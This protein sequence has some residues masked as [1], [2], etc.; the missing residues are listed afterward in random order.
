M[1]TKGNHEKVTKNVR[2]IS[3]AYLFLS[4][5]LHDACHLVGD[6]NL[7]GTLGE[8]DLAVATL[9]S[10]GGGIGQG[11]LVAGDELLTALR[12]V[13]CR[14]LGQGQQVAVDCLVVVG[15]VSRDVHSEGARHAVFAGGAGNGG[16]ARHLVGNI[17]QQGVFGLGTGLEGREGLDILNQMFH[18]V[19]ATERG[20]DVGM[21]TYPAEGPAS[22]TVVR[23]TGFQ[24]VSKFLSHIAEGTTTKG[25]HNDTLDIEFLTFII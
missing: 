9:R 21:G 20:E 4:D 6:A 14:L 3:R 24:L 22:G 1:K 17:G 15:E 10:P 12:I 23:A 11:F 16:E 19:H 8:A 18:A 5:G 2:N 7:L 13:G 25:F